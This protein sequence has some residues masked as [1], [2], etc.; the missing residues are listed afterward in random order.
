MFNIENWLCE[1]VEKLKES[2]NEKLI[3]VG[4]Q[5]SY[6]RKEAN[7]NSDIDMVIILDEVG[8]LELEK[9]KK[10]VSTMDFQEKACGFISG[11]QELQNWSAYELFQ[12]YND[13]KALYGDLKNIIPEPKK[14]DAKLAVKI[15]SESLYHAI[16]HSFLYSK[17]R[18]SDLKVVLKSLFFVLQAKFCFQNGDYINTKKLLFEK[19]SGHEKN[20]LELSFNLNQVDNFEENQIRETYEALIKFASENIKKLS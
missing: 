20:L 17:D 13:T 7:E 6:R 4:Y 18:K 12:L 16:C 15:G 19:L 5:G 9:Y 1:I 3:F 10:I 8:I 14:E 2:F 11:K